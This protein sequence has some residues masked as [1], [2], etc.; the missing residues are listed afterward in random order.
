MKVGLGL[1][2]G[3]LTA[4][5]FRFARQAGA[6]DIIAHLVDY[7]SEFPKLVRNASGDGYVWPRSQM[8][9]TKHLWTQE[10]LADLKSAIE[11]EGLRLAAVENFDPSHWY[12]V[13]LDGPRK[14]QQLEDLK[15][16]VRRVG[17]AGIPIIGYDF[18]VAGVWGHVVGPFARG[19]AE[20][21]AFLGPEGPQETPIP[22]GSVWNVTY[23]AAA[24]AGTVGSVSSEQLW[25]RL[26][27]FLHAVLP[28]AEE[29][30]VRLAAHPDDPPMPTLRGTARLVYQPHHY[31]RLLAIHS[32][33]ANAIE[34]CAG[35]IQ[36]MTEGNVYDAIDE[37][38]RAGRVAYVHLRNLKGKVPRYHEVFIDEGDMDVIKV[39]QILHKNKF[40][41]VLIP[42][43][44]PQMC[45]AAPWHA[46]SAYALGYM[47]AAIRIIEGTR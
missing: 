26:E 23:D 22:N 47:R 40:D 32:S 35:T 46:G 15:T 19:G 12:D 20:S 27:D 42:D 2:C 37:Y 29:V 33:P 7:R 5:H 38:S 44:T 31:R 36:E 28:V 21:V 14:A 10:E 1:Y 3:Q 13:L 24:P 41:G 25:K 4:D 30:G 43:H 34:F 9:S 11:K 39:L 17:R 18:S 45:C 8:T 16:M 6:T